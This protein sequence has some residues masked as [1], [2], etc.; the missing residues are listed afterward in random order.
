NSGG[1]HGEPHPFPPRRSSDL[2]NAQ[3]SH[4]WA[5]E[6]FER[7]RGRRKADQAVSYEP[8]TSLISMLRHLGGVGVLILA[9]LDSSVL[10]TFGARSEEHTS[11]LQSRVDLVCRLL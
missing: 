3:L 1:R 6:L 7:Q 2:G 4:G 9:S 5:E 11:E 8:V 10:P